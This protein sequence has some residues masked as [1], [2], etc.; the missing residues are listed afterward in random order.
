M[1]VC[2]NYIST[3]SLCAASYSL[4]RSGVP[5]SLETWCKVKLTES[6]LTGVHYL[7]GDITDVS[8][9]R[10]AMQGVDTVFHMASLIDYFGHQDSLLQK[11][12]VQGTKSV[13]RAA[14]EAAVKKVVY[15]SSTAV[16]TE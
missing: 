15:T 1:C 4:W 5:L 16:L 7:R 2:V 9:L 3:T 8:A 10:E 6:K 12:N 11:V 14:Q 13:L